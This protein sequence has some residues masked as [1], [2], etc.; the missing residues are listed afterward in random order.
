M[1]VCMYV[2]VYVCV[3]TTVSEVET[4]QGH[5]EVL[6]DPTQVTTLIALTQQQPFDNLLQRRLHLIHRRKVLADE[7]STHERVERMREERER[8][9]EKKTEKDREK[10]NDATTISWI[11]FKIQDKLNTPFIF[12]VFLHTRPF[13]LSL[14]SPFPSSFPLSLSSLQSL[15]FHRSHSL[16]RL[17]RHC[18]LFEQLIVILSSFPFP[19]PK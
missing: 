9:R 16:F 15:T 7:I 11:S 4:S 5:V 2:Y 13:F 14:F 18:S 8:E 19:F 1:Y 6:L 10:E 17:P 3:C 12:G